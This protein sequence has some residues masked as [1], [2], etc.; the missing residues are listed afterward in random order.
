MRHINVFITIRRQLSQF[1]NQPC[2]RWQSSNQSHHSHHPAYCRRVRMRN[3]L[4]HGTSLLYLQP[5]SQNRKITTLWADELGSYS[6]WKGLGVQSGM[7]LLR[8]RGKNF[9]KYKNLTSLVLSLP[10]KW[11]GSCPLSYSL[12]ALIFG[13]QLGWSQ[14]NGSNRTYKWIDLDDHVR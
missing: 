3:P 4:L 12:R 6:T 10:C 11:S 2:H 9:A 5:L 1:S 8:F 13:R 14:R 7:W